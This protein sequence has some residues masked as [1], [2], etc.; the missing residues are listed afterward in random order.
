MEGEFKIVLLASALRQT[1]KKQAQK[2]LIIII[3]KRTVPYSRYTNVPAAA[4]REPRT[5]KMRAMPTLPAE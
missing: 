1:L 5:H 3:K 2:A 4:I